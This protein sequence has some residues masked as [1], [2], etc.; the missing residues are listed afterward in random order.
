[1]VALASVERSNPVDTAVAA[2]V[3][4]EVSSVDVR[5]ALASRFSST[6]SILVL[7]N[8]EHVLASTR[9]LVE[10]LLRDVEDLRVVTTSRRRIGLAD[11][12]VLDIGPS[13]GPGRQR[14]RQSTRASLPRPDRTR[15]AP[16]DRA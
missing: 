5:R 7:D 10:D 2:A 4:V 1:M 15:R 12:A 9:R 11:E 3:G 13:R 14:V 8:C 6:P 16:A